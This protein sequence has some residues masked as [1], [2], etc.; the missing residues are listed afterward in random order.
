MNFGDL[1]NPQLEI[2]IFCPIIGVLSQY[3]APMILIE[4][5]NSA[6]QN[7]LP[8]FDEYSTS[9]PGSFTVRQTVFPKHCVQDSFGGQI[10]FWHFGH[11]GMTNLPFFNSASKML[12]T[13]ISKPLKMLQPQTCFVRDQSLGFQSVFSPIF[14]VTAL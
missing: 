10:T 3:N 14:P 7:I 13:L 5:S 9:M 1:S 2:L 6:I 4:F 11:S 8:S 12:M